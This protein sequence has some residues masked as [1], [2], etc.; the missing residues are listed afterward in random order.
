MKKTGW[1][2]WRAKGHEGGPGAVASAPGIFAAW[3]RLAGRRATLHTS[4]RLSGGVREECGS[5]SMTIFNKDSFP[6]SDLDFRL[7]RDGGVVAYHADAVLADDL[8]WFERQGYLVRQFDGRAWS[9]E[10]AFH[11]S[12]SRALEFP[13][14]CG[15]NLDAFND[16]MRDFDV[17]LDGGLVFVIR[18]A[19][20]VHLQCEWFH[21]VLQILA[22]VVRLNLLFGRRFL[23]LLQSEN[24][25]IV[26]PDLGA[27][28]V[29]WNPREWLNSSR[30]L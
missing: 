25:A 26:F 19:G 20:D 12:I 30:G 9:N 17:P 21:F 6:W 24:P 8:Q 2:R 22:D 16:C 18:N 28:T 3:G 14:Y 7:L 4:A 1:C 10:S 23:V 5:K 29:Q 15:S 13:S 11:E 27:F